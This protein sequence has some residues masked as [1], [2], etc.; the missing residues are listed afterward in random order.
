MIEWLY[1]PLEGLDAWLT[2][3]MDGA[4]I[5]VALG[6]AFVLGLRHASD[7]DHLVA[8]TSLVALDG[9][10]VR[11]GTRLGWWWGWGHAATLVVIGVPLIAFKARLPGWL[12]AGAEKAIGVLVF[13]LALRVLVKWVRGGYRVS[14]HE[15]APADDHVHRHVHRGGHGHATQR[16]G[17]QAAAIGVLHGLGGTGAVVVLLIAAIPAQA[18]AAAALGVFAVMSALSMAMFTSA[19]AWLLTRPLVEPLY[20]AVLVP[21]LGMFGMLF[22]MWYAGIG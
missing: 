21:C 8:V 20:R 10:D 5:V 7:P 6:I 1:A 22:G 12:E 17:R 16:T 11:R 2:A 4:P 18:A 13:V 3:L 15:H 19:Y 14:R 9:G